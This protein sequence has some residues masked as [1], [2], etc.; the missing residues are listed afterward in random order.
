MSS[1]LGRI[2]EAAKGN[3][4][5]R[6][7]SLFHHL[8]VDLLI[9]AYKALNP[10]AVPGV[11]G[12]TWQE[13]GADYVNRI[14]DL[15]GC[16]HRGAYRAKPSKRMYLEKPDGRKRPIG[17]AALEDKIVQQATVWV[18][19]AIYEVDF[20]GFSYG[21]RPGR[22]P[23]NALDAVYVA[24]TKRRVNWVLDADVQSFFDRLD[25]ECLLKFLQHR[26]GDPRLLRLIQKWLQ[27]GV[28]DEGEWTSTTVG[29]PQGA[30]ISPILANIY[31]HYVLDLWVE[32][33]R[34]GHARGEVYI[35]RY[36]DDFVLGFQYKDD[37]VRLRT[38][39]TDRLSSFGLALHKQKT[40]LIQF[41]RFADKD[42]R[43]G[44]DGKPE[45]FDFLGFTH[46]CSKYRKDGRFTVKR[47]S[48]R[49]RLRRKVQ[50]IGRLLRRLRHLSVP[51][52]GA[53][54]RSVVRGFFQYHAVPGNYDSLQR[55]RRLISREWLRALRR[56]SQKDRCS[57][58]RLQQLVARWLPRP[59]ILHPYPDRRLRVTTQGR[60]RMR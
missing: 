12:E 54:L 23:H 20:L 32:Q 43:D 33:W 59:R 42:R 50:A 40:R 36:A 4:Q 47:K 44:G 35:V 3:S 21:F 53:W 2:R 16:L 10:K 11:D 17:I 39:L 1:G 28:S 18:L 14:R 46:I 6:F 8:T 38:A 48:S 49:D 34:E 41:G 13:Y 45:T 31:L 25:H 30:V 15:H 22:G 58:K 29:T 5:T 26:I 51:Q 52:L 37:A 56:R 24:L 57:W 9:R 55:F 19:E 60:S 7:T 27:A